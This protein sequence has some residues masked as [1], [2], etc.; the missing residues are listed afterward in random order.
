MVIYQRNTFQYKD[1]FKNPFLAISDSLLYNDALKHNGVDQLNET[2][3]ELLQD[4]K[5]WD[6]TNNH[7]L[8]LRR[9]WILEC[10]EW[11]SGMHGSKRNDK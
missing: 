5:F 3:V 9:R 2:W 6:E 7:T 11:L 4:L 1:F 8:Y 10:A